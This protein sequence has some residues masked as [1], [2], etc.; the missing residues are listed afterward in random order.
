MFNKN[1]FFISIVLLILILF[2]IFNF[3]EFSYIIFSQRFRGNNYFSDYYEFSLALLEFIFITIVFLLLNN[4]KI[5]HIWLIKTFVTL[6]LMLFYEAHYA[7]DAYVYA[8]KAI[9]VGNI[10]I[11]GKNNTENVAFFNHIFTYIV[12]NSYYSLKL[13][14][15]FIGFLGLIFLYKSYEYIMYKNNL[16][17]EENFIYFF[18]LFPSIIFWSSILG[19][20]PL[21]LFFVG[22]FIFSFLH[23]IDE[24][25]FRYIIMIVISIWFVSYIRS[26]YSVIMI[27]SMF[28][29]FLKLNSIKNF[30]LFILILPLFLLFVGELLQSRGITSFD[31]LFIKMSETTKNLAYGNSVGS[32]F[33]ITGL[34]TYLLYFIPNLF[35]T[36]FRPMPWDIR[37]P[38][39]LMAAIENVILFYLSY[40]YIFKNWKDIYSNK[41]LKFLIL[42][43]F[44][45]S[46]LYVIISPANLGGAARFKLQVLPAMIMIIGIAM[47][48]R[49]QNEDE[50]TCVE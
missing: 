42:F 37:N 13:F 15:S 16:K 32:V 49:K 20:D 38:F 14:N 44:S 41:Y 47:S 7:L 2:L 29:Y 39:T 19:K 31:M 24:I 27:G 5:L 43:I 1:F 8:A 26:W 36:L 40:K 23:I 48:M 12:G 21:N 33:Q 10:P 18:F 35:T 30:I 17:I 22:M 3:S 34:G 4:K 45:W 50:K 25:K 28:F 11:F 46:L 6:I 9:G